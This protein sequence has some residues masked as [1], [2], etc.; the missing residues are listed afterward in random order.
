M[1]FKTSDKRMLA[2]GITGTLGIAS[3]GAAFR[4]DSIMNFL[5]G[6]EFGGFSVF[7]ILSILLLWVAWILYNKEL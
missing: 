3:L 5:Q 1:G 7:A 2:T 4:V 6:T